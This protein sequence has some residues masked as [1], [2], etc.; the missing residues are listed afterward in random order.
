VDKDVAGGENCRAGNLQDSISIQFWNI[1]GEGMR[2]LNLKLLVKRKSA[3]RLG[4][5]LSLNFA[6]LTMATREE[7]EFE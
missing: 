4:K 3:S 5:W 7:P 6:S 1:I 2:K